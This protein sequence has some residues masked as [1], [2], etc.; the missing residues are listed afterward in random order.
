MNKT[1]TY[2]PIVAILL[3]VASCAKQPAI[4]DL[5][6]AN[7]KSSTHLIPADIALASLNAF[8]EN[9]AGGQTKSSAFDSD[10]ASY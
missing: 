4:A 8:L 3:L 5:P 7:Q 1:K 6:V 10:V 2:W 9:P